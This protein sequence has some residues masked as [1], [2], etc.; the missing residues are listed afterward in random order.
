MSSLKR[1]RKNRRKIELYLINDKYNSFEHVIDTLS[2]TL[3]ECSPIR[4]EQIA[5]ITHNNEACHIYTGKS[6]DVYYVQTMLIKQ[7]LHVVAKNPGKN[8]VN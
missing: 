5:N 7:G 3:P 6:P 2:N 1:K 4:A 8:L